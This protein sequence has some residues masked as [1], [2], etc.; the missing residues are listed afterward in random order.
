[1]AKPI[2]YAP[3]NQGPSN[4]SYGFTMAVFFG[5]VWLLKC[6]KNQQFSSSSAL[7]IAIAFC[8]AT[9][10]APGILTFPN[11]LWMRFGLLLQKIVSP[12]VL[13]IIYFGIFTPYGL[14]IKFLGKDSFNKRFNPE[15]QTYWVPRPPDGDIQLK[16]QF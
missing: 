6:L 2:L 15:A 12:I 9:L 5:L 3:E 13:A 8:G 4:H 10:V 7:Y 1:M 14:F 11:K 16:N